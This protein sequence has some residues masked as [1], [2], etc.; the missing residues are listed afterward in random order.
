M[1][2]DAPN[3]IVLDRYDAVRAALSSK[4][5]T[6]GLDKE[7]YEVGNVSESTL[8]TLHGDGHRDRRRVENQLFR[9][10][11][12]E[13]YERV[14]FPDILEQTISTFVDPSASDLMEIGG[15]LS[16][17]LSAR[18]AGVDF[19]IDSLPQRQRLREYLHTFALGTAIDVA[20]G[21]VNEIKALM[22]ATLAAFD[23][24][25]I[26]TSWARRQKLINLHYA[27][28]L[29]EEGLPADVLTTLL[30]ARHDGLLDMDDAL[31]L[32]EVTEFFAAGAHTS[33]QTLAN[34]FH[35]LFAWCQEH[36][37]DWN[38]LAG[39][40]Y[41]AQRAVQ[42]ALR[43]RPTNPMIHRRAATDTT[44]AGHRIPTGA[45]VL[46]STAVANADVD[47]YGP[48]AGQYNP[49]RLCPKDAAPWGMSFGH[50]I[51]LCIG[52]TLA[53][54]VPVRGDNEPPEPDR[55]YGLITHAVQALVRRG[56]QAHPTDPPVPDTKTERYTR[57][58]SYP[59]HFRYPAP[60]PA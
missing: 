59:V 3:R 51:H 45:I 50:G 26:A 17:V 52:R 12:L 55:L 42:E 18:T 34:S 4:D 20:H 11:T 33:T 21:D 6:R 2:D 39:D 24:E 43:V 31:L 54:G 22:M 56:I 47:A 35:L 7:L 46:L 41:F 10:S 27:G 1:A 23:E 29:P 25:F 16:V 57:W 40:V 19:D 37:D 48:D 44:V 15:L 9:R 49:H 13:T 58:A 28:R 38:R 53:V 36:P 8:S 14:L 30:R 60:T 5:L 32:R